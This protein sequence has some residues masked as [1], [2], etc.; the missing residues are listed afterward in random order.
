MKAK[1]ISLHGA[2]GSGKTTL[3]GEL[4]V[5]FKKLGVRVEYVSELARQWAMIERPVTGC[6]QVYLFASQLHA[7]DTPL[8]RGKADLVI[9]DSPLYLSCYYTS[10]SPTPMYTTPLLKC[11]NEFDK[12]YS[13][14]NF[15][16]HPHPDYVFHTEGRYCN[17]DD[18]HIVSGDILRF[19]RD[20]ADVIELPNDDRLKYIIGYLNGV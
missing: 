2:A 12:Q 6:D 15:F 11:A 1:R 10:V 13:N 16:C 20:Q 19:V 4:F 5:Y 3:A 18:S 9:T 17:K 14:V 8:S 7:E